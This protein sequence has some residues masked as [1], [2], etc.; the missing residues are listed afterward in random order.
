M[1]NQ[2]VIRK[3]H[4]LDENQ[5]NKWDLNWL[6]RH[7]HA[8]TCISDWI[9]SMWILELIT[10]KEQRVKFKNGTYVWNGFWNI[11]FGNERKRRVYRLLCILAPVNNWI[12]FMFMFRYSS[13]VQTF[14]TA[15]SEL[16]WKEFPHHTN[17][18]VNDYVHHAQCKFI[19]HLTCNGEAVS[20]SYRIVSVFG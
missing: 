14:M 5:L 16:I 6:C 7:C 17:G 13:I 1:S 18:N 4:K 10:T 15:I 11:M 9:C 8:V 12:M 19:T 20:E 3:I 2:K